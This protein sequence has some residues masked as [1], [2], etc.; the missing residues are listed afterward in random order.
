MEAALRAL[1]ASS[2]AV[3]AHA[4]ATRINWGAHPQGAGGPYLVMF[5]IDGSE[6]L[7]M[8]GPDG[9]WQGRVQIDAYAATIDA[10]HQLSVA[11]TRLLHGY[12]GGGFR[13]IRHGATR[14]HGRESGTN[15]AERLFRIG[16][17]FFIS[18]RAGHAD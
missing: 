7:H 18:W 11:V 4:D 8:Q 15:E 5:V 3:T 2:A 13:L 1:L 17:D 14:H 12:R 16:M 6:G 10:A 9:L